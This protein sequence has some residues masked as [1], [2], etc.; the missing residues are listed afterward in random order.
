MIIFD[1]P[2]GLP[3]PS[4]SV[5]PNDIPAWNAYE[6]SHIEA[7]FDFADSFLHDNGAILVFLP[8]SPSIRMDVKSYAASYDFKIFKDWWGINELR[9]TSPLNSNH[10]VSDVVTNFLYL[11]LLH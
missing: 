6:N 7:L 8:E 10:T 3:V 11:V 9:L 4:L 2:E 1:V 5:P